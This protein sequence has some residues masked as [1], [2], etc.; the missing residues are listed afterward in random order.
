[1]L[2]VLKDLSFINFNSITQKCHGSYI[3]VVGGEDVGVMWTNIV[4]QT[5]CAYEAIYFLLSFVVTG[6]VYEYS[7]RTHERRWVSESENGS[8]F[9]LKTD[10][11]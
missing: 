9:K 11:K 3:R 2:T 6:R 5:I 10:E 1:M 8:H 4:E 7:T